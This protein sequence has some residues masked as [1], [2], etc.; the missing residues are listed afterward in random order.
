MSELVKLAGLGGSNNPL[1][2]VDFD[3][4]DISTTLSFVIFIVVSLSFCP[5]PI[6]ELFV[7]LSRL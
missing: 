7:I 6:I 4:Y 3:K 1:L 2:K 5:I